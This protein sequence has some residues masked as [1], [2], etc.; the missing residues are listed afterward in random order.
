MPGRPKPS[1]YIRTNGRLIS[2]PID[3]T[4]PTN[5]PTHRQTTQ[6]ISWPA[7]PT[8]QATPPTKMHSQPSQ[9]TSQPVQP[10]KPGN[11]PIS[12]PTTKLTSWHRVIGIV[13]RSVKCKNGSLPLLATV[14]QR[15][16]I[17][18]IVA[19][20]PIYGERVSKSCTFV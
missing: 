12:H 13:S 15:T 5:Y 19:S 7:N 11:S 4:M 14:C 1:G 16:R 10:N 2:K 18:F 6:S 3:H 17:T 8:S 9:P 20:I